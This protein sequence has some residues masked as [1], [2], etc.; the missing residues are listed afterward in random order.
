MSPRLGHVAFLTLARGEEPHAE[1]VD[2]AAPDWRE[3][4]GRSQ[5]QRLS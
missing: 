3:R 1:I 2:L 4:A 5:A